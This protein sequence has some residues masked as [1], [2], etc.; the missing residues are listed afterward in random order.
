[1]TDDEQHRLVMLCAE[2]VA[3][4]WTLEEIPRGDMGGIVRRMDDYVSVRLRVCLDGVKVLT[5][6]STPVAVGRAIAYV[7]EADNLWR[8]SMY[9]TGASGG[10]G[11]D[12]K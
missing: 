2:F 10:T 7:L 8:A 5:A 6:D 12:R 4:G 3:A 11:G 9:R 1:V